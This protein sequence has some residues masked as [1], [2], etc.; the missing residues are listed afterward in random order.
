MTEGR[1]G[2][3]R[4]LSALLGEAE[5]PLGAE[6]AVVGPGQGQQVPIE[7]LR[8]NPDQPRRLFGEAEMTELT[9]SVRERGVLQPILVR[10]APGAPGEYQIVAG[11]RRWRAAQ[12]AG[13]HTVPILLRALDDGEVAEIGIIENIQRADLNVLE[14]AQGYRLLL[15][16]FG[17]T[18][19]SIAKTVGKS[20]SHVANALRLLNLPAGVREHLEAGRLSAGHAR[21]IAAAPDPERLARTIVDGDLTVRQAEALARQGDAISDVAPPPAR[22]A[23]PARTKDAD[24]RALEQDLSDALG[25][26]VQIVDRKGAGEVRVRYATLEPA[27]Q[28]LPASGRRLK[29]SGRRNT[30]IGA[31]EAFGGLRRPGRRLTRFKAGLHTQEQSGLQP[32]GGHADEDVGGALG[33]DDVEFGPAA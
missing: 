21:A 5:P 6:N 19:E 1:R 15:D 25:L 30:A 28:P 18:Q 7:L 17:R 26:A 10:P 31:N 22:S 32:A 9:D 13:L 20:R 16:R 2:L 24:T 23:G 14:E 8:R 11:E 12:R 33:V 27:R 29:R 4:G 3:G